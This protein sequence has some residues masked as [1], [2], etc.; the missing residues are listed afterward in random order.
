MSNLYKTNEFLKSEV[1]NNQGTIKRQTLTDDV[2]NH[3]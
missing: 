1:L 2:L 3:I